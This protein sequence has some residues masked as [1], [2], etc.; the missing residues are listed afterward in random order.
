LRP[1][2]HLQPAKD[3]AVALVAVAAAAA[4]VSLAELVKAL[5]ARPPLGDS[6]GLA[7]PENPIAI[8]GDAV[9]VSN[10]KGHD[11]MKAFGPY[12]HRD[13][14]RILIRQGST[15]RARSFGSEAEAK[16][17]IRRLRAEAHRQTSMTV[18]KS[19]EAYAEQLRRNGLKERSI[20]TATFRLTRFFHPVLLEPLATL[21][22][23]KAKHLYES[24]SGLAVDTRLNMLA[25]AKSFCRK[26]REH[27]WTETLL[28]AD[29][30]GEG[31]RHCGKAKLSLDESRKYLATCLGQATS[32]D[33]QVKQAAIAACMPLVFGLRSGEVLNRQAKDIDDGGR[34]LRITSAKSRAGIRS[35]Q[36]PDWFRPYLIDLASGIK[37]DDRI[38]PR[39]KTWLHRQVVNTCKLA[40]V[41]RVVPHGLRGTHGDLALVAAATPLQVSQALGHES[42]T[43]TFRHYASP[44]LAEANVHQAAVAQLA[45]ITQ[46]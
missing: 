35:L 38:F 6:Q 12:P 25:L 44:Q 3:L 36:V 20:A 8:D 42:L 4:K 11:A 26:A 23:S 39:E 41:S 13:R 31:R 18:E 22:A 2:D 16:A 15:Q 37:P 1:D 7:L 5:A 19:I 40:G 32:S 45:P 9:G 28:L 10:P 43:T 17:E 30:K 14:W 27:D 46:Y 29:V 21:S 33:P 24:L 34:I